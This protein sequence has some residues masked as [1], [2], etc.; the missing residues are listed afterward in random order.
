MLDEDRLC[1]LFFLWLMILW[2]FFQPIC[3]KSYFKHKTNFDYFQIMFYKC[4]SFK[5][6]WSFLWR[7]YNHWR[8]IEDRNESWILTWRLEATIITLTFCLIKRDK[9]LAIQQKSMWKAVFQLIFLTHIS[10]N[11]NGSKYSL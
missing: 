7:C 2:W 4:V 9:V 5:Y 1:F 8:S 11:Y 10:S 3:W 6:P